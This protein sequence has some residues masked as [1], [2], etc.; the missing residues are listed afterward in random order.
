MDDRL[1]EPEPEA[2]GGPIGPGE[3][4]GMGWRV[5]AADFGWLFLA[6]LIVEAILLGL[7]LIPCLNY[8]A[9]VGQ[10]FLYPPLM[11]GLFLVV[12][13]RVDGSP[14]RAGGVFQAFRHR[15]WESVVA[16]LP[17]TLTALGLGILFFVV[18]MVGQVGLMTFMETGMPAGPGGPAGSPD[19]V[20]AELFGR[21]GA[22]YGLMFLLL[23]ARQFLKG[24]VVLVFV[25]GL[26]AVWDYP[27]QGWAAA[28][29][30]ASLVREHLGVALA[31]GLVFAGLYLVASLGWVFC[32]VGAFATYA[33]FDAWF[34]ATMLFLYRSW[35]G[36]PLVQT[37][38]TYEM[39]AGADFQ[40]AGGGY[41]DAPPDR[42]GPVPPTD[43]SP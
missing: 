9:S 25:I 5:L 36:Q 43:V 22:M 17:I 20:F 31:V 1:A 11:A 4:L 14:A 33:I 26:A 41:D 7:Y 32:C 15:Y 38:M 19:K 37:P 18:Q 40:A 28:R 42:Q 23:L 34:A 24:L 12:R 21:I 29:H 30:A 13:Q 35:T 10:I 2:A 27:K 3:A 8:L 39:L 6:G 16:G